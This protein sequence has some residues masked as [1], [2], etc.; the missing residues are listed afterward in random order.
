MV[1]VVAVLTCVVL[2]AVL[3][4]FCCGDARCC[5]VQIHFTVV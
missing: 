5:M 2:Q 3:A 1:F 4:N